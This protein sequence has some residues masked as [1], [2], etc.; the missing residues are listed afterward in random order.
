MYYSRHKEAAIAF[1]EKLDLFS[2]VAKKRFEVT[3][4][5]FATGLRSVSASKSNRLVLFGDLD[6][7]EWALRVL[8]RSKVRGEG[9]MP[10]HTAKR[11]INNLMVGFVRMLYLCAALT[12]KNRR[13]PTE[14][15]SCFDL[16]LL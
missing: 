11:N 5:R 13:S 12:K 16:P 8:K 6:H 14:H 1:V 2:K 9:L 4:N 15:C 7:Q 10:V 3:R